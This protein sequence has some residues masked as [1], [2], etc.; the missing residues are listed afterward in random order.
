MTHF[1][2][3]FAFVPDLSETNAKIR[4]FVAFSPCFSGPAPWR[5]KGSLTP[6]PRSLFLFSVSSLRRRSRAFLARLG[7]RYRKRCPAAVSRQP[8]RKSGH[9]A[10]FPR[11]R[12]SRHAE[13]VSDIPFSAS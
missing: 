6:R 1:R 5:Q 11:G 3:F 4:F 13:T 12:L 10:C 2:A 9:E 7:A 8:F